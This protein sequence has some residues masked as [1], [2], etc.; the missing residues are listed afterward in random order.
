MKKKLIGIIVCMM[1]IISIVPVGGN[2]FIA[3]GEPP[4]VPRNPEPENGSYNV[5]V[6]TKLSW[7]GGDPDPN[8]ILYYYVY[9]G[10]NPEPYLSFVVGPY[11]ANQT[12]IQC[13][14]PDW[15]KV[16]YNKTYYWQVKTCDDYGHGVN[17]STTGPVWHFTTELLPMPPPEVEIVNPRKGY[18]HFLGIPFF[19]TALNLLAD[20]VSFGGFRL[21]PIQV[22]ATDGNGES[23]D[24]MVR[25]YINDAITNP[26]H[27]NKEL[28]YGTWN[29]ETGY[30]EWQWAE[31]A[32]GVYRLRVKA[33]D[34]YGSVS[35]WASFDVRTFCFIL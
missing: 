11:P 28:G 35:N 21:R 19:P 32:L 22:N 9:F 20:A 31:L 3:P 1:L 6:H 29:P 24:L 30:Y 7:D 25:L 16:K 34:I 17:E 4:F 33:E 10:N 2:L 26:V 5:S 13:Y 18:F 8:D 14:I 12:R 27:I 23:K 15:V